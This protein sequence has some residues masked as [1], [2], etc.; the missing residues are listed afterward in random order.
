MK[1]LERLNDMNR[2]GHTL[3]EICSGL[4]EV[5]MRDQIQYENKFIFLRAIGEAEWRSTN[6]T[7]RILL[8]WLV[9]SIKLQQEKT[10]E[11]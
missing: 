6:M 8:S 4:H 11:R 7:P 5:V 3:Q 1:A 9:S 2:K 10:Q